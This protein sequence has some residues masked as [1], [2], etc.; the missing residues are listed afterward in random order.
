MKS[1]LRSAALCTAAAGAWMLDMPSQGQRMPGLVPTAHA[2]VGMPM[3]PVSYAGVARRT[4]YRE[5]EV[6]RAAEVARTA[7]GATVATPAAGASTVVVASEAN[8]AAAARAAAVPAPV[9]RAAP[10][11]GTIV[12]TLPPG[13][14]P[15]ALN[16]V[17][18][19]RCGSTYYRSA[20][21]GPNLVFV[22]QQP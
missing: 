2:I 22:V 20:F 6:V 11:V 19:Q 12:S 5:T 10:A 16:G 9:P 7:E 17:E 4:A 18:Y 1:V 8:A 3:T 15:T 13:C 21:N 14:T